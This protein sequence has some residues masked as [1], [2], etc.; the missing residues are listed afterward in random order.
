M[1]VRLPKP[2]DCSF[3]RKR[4]LFGIRV[5]TGQILCYGCRYVLFFERYLTL[6]EEFAGQPFRL[7]PWQREVL[8]DIFGTI[9]PETGLRQYEDVYLRVAKKNA[10]STFVA[11]LCVTALSLASAGGSTQKILGAATAMKQARYVYEPAATMV[12]ASDELG[13]RLRILDS[14]NRIIRRDQPST[15][16][17]VVS[18]DGDINDGAN[19]SM[20]ICDEL[21]RWR[22][23][24]SEELYAI[25]RRGTIT[26]DEP[27]HIDITTAGEVGESP[28][29][30]Q[31]EEYCDNIERGVTEDPR[32][33]F[34]RWGADLKKY[35]WDSRE[36]RVQ[37]NPSHEDNGG[38]LKDSALEKFCREA[39]N[40]PSKKSEYLRYHLN[41]W[42]DAADPVIDMVR[43][44]ENHGGYDLWKDPINVDDLIHLWGLAEKP[45]FVGVDI[46]SSVDLTAVVL[47]FPPDTEDGVFTVLPFFWMPGAR[48]RERELQDKVPYSQWVDRG[49]ITATPGEATDYRSVV[50]RIRWASQLFSVVSYHFDPANSRQISVPLI[51]EGYPCQEIL[52]GFQS[53]NDPT[54]K[55]IELYLSRRLRHANHPVL[56][57]NA[58]CMAL[59]RDRQGR[60][61]PDK[62]DRARNSKR[63]DGIAALVDAIGGYL[64]NPQK[65]SIFSSDETAVI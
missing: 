9:N 46:A 41:V 21:H 50:D 37:A 36:A 8:S 49:L 48:L 61:M 11:G 20:A 59:N 47:L 40:D 56:N 65:T 25:L 14:T 34:R 45:C 10:K 7:M 23:R 43:W 42:V 3:C 31:R 33:Y 57:W 35:A 52:Q 58:S 27:L 28:I 55:L 24:K 30:Y 26:R 5:K 2:D 6:T 39:Q 44:R 13:R 32:F 16:Y 22:T 53:L 63:I 38:Y 64:T 60:I 17:M 19:P 29:C 12:R 62:P 1:N 4:V 15:Y 51:D 54:S 18:A